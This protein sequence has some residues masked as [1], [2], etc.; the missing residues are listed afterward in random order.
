MIS[1][2]KVISDIKKGMANLA[3]VIKTETCSK[4]YVD[5]KI[6]ELVN[7]APE[8]LDTLQELSQALNNDKDFAATINNL[9]AQKLDK[10]GG[11]VT[12]DLT[13]NGTLNAKATSATTAES[14]TGNAASA[15]SVAWGGVTG[16]PATYPAT[17]HTHAWG[18]ITGAPATA[19]RWP[20]WGE[21]TGKPTSM[22]AN[23]GTASSLSKFFTSDSA[24]PKNCNDMASNSVC[25]YT[26]GGPATSLGA[27]TNDG[28][29]YS[30]AYSTSWVGQIAQDYR[31]GSL[32]VRGK[33]NG[34]WTAW[35]RIVWNEGTWGIN[36]T[37]SAGSVAY[38]N[39]TGKPTLLK[40]QSWDASTGT[41]TIANA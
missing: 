40:V 3:N 37:G 26:S 8:Q 29:L 9:L 23:G 41:L 28:A 34:T 36:V 1:L 18:N 35:K 38:G 32:F 12:G 5:Q 11:T 25:Y 10:S 15:S 4:E 2:A 22:P 7:S 14:C 21:V 17:E 20:A 31:N 6:A 27:S 19:T 24:A 13:V 16:K 30:Q 39:V 33:N